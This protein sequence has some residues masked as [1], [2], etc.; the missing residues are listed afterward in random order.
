M[1]AGRDFSDADTPSTPLVAIVNSTFVR[2]VTNGQN[3]VGRRF[4]VEATPSRP[5]TAY[6]VVGVVEDATYLE[7]RE[8]PYPV[9]FLAL[10]QVPRPGEYQRIIVRSS[11]PQAAVTAGITETLQQLNPSVV[12]SFTSLKTQ[13]LD[14]LARERLMATLSG[15]FGALAGLLAVIGL[16]G[17][18]S[19]TVAR[20]T[21][22]IG[23]RMALGASRAA[24]VR[25]IMREAS[26]LIVI[27]IVLGTVLALAT[28]RT[29]SALL[30]GL[31]SYDPGTLGISVFALALVA[32][33][34]SYL[35]ARAA[36][37]IEPVVALR[38]E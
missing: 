13:V 12:V 21:N 14:T 35:P 17:V 24:V 10:N 30:F 16:Y 8:D 6:L 9:V 28:G 25:M 20:R 5:E 18:I 38:V 32:L 33:A 34:A 19:Y 11:M 23:V 7:L 37:T 15:F 22:E 3:P 29:A 26:L 1:A 31:E 2:V 4:K 36:A 27:G